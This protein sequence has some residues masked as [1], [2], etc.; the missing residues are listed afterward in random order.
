[1]N[2]SQDLLLNFCDN[3]LYE[4]VANKIYTTSEEHRGGPLAPY[5]IVQL[6]VKTTERT[7]WAIINKLQQFKLNKIPNENV[8][9]AIAIICSAVIRLRAANRMPDDM[10]HIVLDIFL[11]CSIYA[12]KSHFQTLQTIESSKITDWEAILK[13][14]E[15]ESLPEDG[16]RRTLAP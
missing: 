7:A 2:W 12:F 1:L 3:K 4:E 8:N 10:Y 13:E 14:A 6:T 11:S 9:T 5:F 16:V 15:Q